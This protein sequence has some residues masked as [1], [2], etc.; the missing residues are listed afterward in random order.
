MIAPIQL[1]QF[2]RACSVL[3]A[4][5]LL[6]PTIAHVAQADILVNVYPTLAPNRFG[7]PSYDAWVANTIAALQNGSSSGGTPG[8]PSYYQQIAGGS[9]LPTSSIIVT[10]FPSW[11]GN[12]DPAGTYG[13]G[14]GSELGNRL[15]FSLT[16]RGTLG[17]TFSI[18]QLSFTATSSDPGNQ[19]GFSFAAGSYQYGIDYVGINLGA[20]HLAG[21]TGI[22]ADTIITSG[23]NTQLVDILYG[24]GS[25]SAFQV[26]SSDP[27]AT[28]QERID[29]AVLAAGSFTFTGTYSL[30]GV[31]GSSFENFNV[32]PEPSVVALLLAALAAVAWRWVVRRPSRQP[33]PVP[34]R[35]DLRH[36][37]R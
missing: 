13:A 34:V 28:N 3:A 36:R 30:G 31:S 4:V 14:F 37:D 1:F 17:T 16:L 18:S 23:P 8:T 19:L 32:I 11:L 6:S 2:P 26:L 25:G 33:V 22:N 9:D 21:G 20:D 10:N 27:G 15:L 29:L 35:D 12:A 7:S 5:V 24:R